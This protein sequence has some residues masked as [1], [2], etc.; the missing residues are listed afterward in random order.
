MSIYLLKTMFFWC[1]VFNYSVLILWVLLIVVARDAFYRLNSRLFGVSKQAF[2]TVN[3]AGIVGFKSL[4]LI[5]NLGPYV[6]L[7]VAT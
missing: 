2:D 6:G 3:Y 1:L 5:F 7:L 4:V